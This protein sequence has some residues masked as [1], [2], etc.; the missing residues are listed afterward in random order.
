MKAE[1]LEMQKNK[2]ID[3]KQF[4]LIM[5][6]D[7]FDKEKQLLNPQKWDILLDTIIFNMKSND[8]KIK[9]LRKLKRII[10]KALDDNKYRKIRLNTKAAFKNIILVDGAM[11]FLQFTG[12]KHDTSNNTIQFATDNVLITYIALNALTGK[13]PMLLKIKQLQNTWQQMTDIMSIHPSFTNSMET[14]AKLSSMNLYLYYENY[15]EIFVKVVKI[16]K[17]L[18]QLNQRQQRYAPLKL[19]QELGLDLGLG[20]LVAQSLS[21]RLLLYLVSVYKQIIEIEAEKQKQDEILEEKFPCY[22]NEAIHN[23]YCLGD[24]LQ[25]HDKLTDTWKT[26]IVINKTA[27]WIVIHFDGFSKKYD[28]QIHVKYTKMRRMIFVEHNLIHEQVTPNMQAS[29]ENELLDCISTILFTVKNVNIRTKIMSNINEIENVQIILKAFYLLI[30]L[31]YLNNNIDEVLVH[32]IM[33]I[34]Q[35]TKQEI[36]FHEQGVHLMV[37]FLIED[38]LIFD[39]INNL[40]NKLE[41]IKCLMAKGSLGTLLLLHRHDIVASELPLI[42]KFLNDVHD[43]NVMDEY[44]RNHKDINIRNIKDDILQLQLLSAFLINMQDIN[45]MCELL[46]NYKDINITNVKEMICVEFSHNKIDTEGMMQQL[47]GFYHKDVD[48]LE[49]N[50]LT[51]YLINVNDAYLLANVLKNIETMEVNM[52]EFFSKIWLELIDNNIDKLSILKLQNLCRQTGQLVQNCGKILLE[53]SVNGILNAIPQEIKHIQ[54]RKHIQKYIA[55]NF[56][57][58]KTQIEAREQQ[59]NFETSAKFGKFLNIMQKYDEIINNQSQLE[60]SEE[61]INL[62]K[63]FKLMNSTLNI[64]NMMDIFFQLKNSG[65]NLMHYEFQQIERFYCVSNNCKILDAMVQTRQKRSRLRLTN[66]RRNIKDEEFEEF[67]MMELLDFIHIRLFHKEEQYRQILP[68]RA[69]QTETYI[70]QEGILLKDDLKAISWFCNENEYDS[71]ALF[72]DIFVGPDEQSNAYLFYQCNLKND[73]NQYHL[74]KHKLSK[75]K[76]EPFIYLFKDEINYNFEYDVKE[77]QTKKHYLLIDKDSTTQ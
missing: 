12:F 44:L 23:P 21:K 68:N 49:I 30:W 3:F 63:L 64:S 56:P 36:L 52:T 73:M 10:L 7:K 61:N 15:I 71:E 65:H 27:N 40:T 42:S 62:R 77:D 2:K 25:I 20:I 26:G 22:E 33:K 32:Q 19:L 29:S 6:M 50:L 31:E 9:R 37:S 41:T 60:T 5:H 51:E 38:K 16:K 75:Y 58:R 28:E 4:D 69:G 66:R 57:K 39:R 53:Q 45:V 24:W 54:W 11:M 34:C 76:I 43:I 46:C 17:Q 48:K 72:D 59:D 74:L 55:T 1:M 70:K 18:N 14:V 47:M 8:D 35:E 67:S 13:I